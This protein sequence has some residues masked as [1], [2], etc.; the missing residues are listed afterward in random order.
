MLTIEIS[1]DNDAFYDDTV[2]RHN[3]THELRRCLNRII[4]ALETG[5][6]DGRIM[7]I[8]GNKVGHWEVDDS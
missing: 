8:N 7:D 2:T 4:A 1:T 6:T 3:R 5:T